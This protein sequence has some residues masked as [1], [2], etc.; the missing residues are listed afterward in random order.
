MGLF[1][2]LTN[3]P[4]LRLFLRSPPSDHWFVRQISV[5]ALNFVGDVGV[6]CWVPHPGSRCRCLSSR[7]C[8]SSPTLCPCGCCCLSRSFL[9]GG[10]CTSWIR[11][12][13]HLHALYWPV[14][15]K[16]QR[17]QSYL[18]GIWWMEESR[19]KCCPKTY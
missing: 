2:E 16:K 7:S 8:R 19:K 4:T 6:D 5:D 1:A 3:K 12:G 15:Q 11:K 13:T 14:V 18:D 17:L 9:H 10:H